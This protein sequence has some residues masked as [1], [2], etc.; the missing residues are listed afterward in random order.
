[1]FIY[2][3]K[4]FSNIREMFANNQKVFGN[5]WR[6]FANTWKMCANN[7]QKMCVRRHPTCLGSRG[8]VPPPPERYHEFVSIGRLIKPRVN[9]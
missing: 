9:K 4:T 5:T 7:I 3:L 2:L 8:N 6:M 1:M